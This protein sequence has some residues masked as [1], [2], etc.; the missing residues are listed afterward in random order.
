MTAERLH[1]LVDPAMP[2]LQDLDATQGITAS[3]RP[4]NQE[5]P[6]HFIKNI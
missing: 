1:S 6:T 3:Q 5:I 4:Y 2:K